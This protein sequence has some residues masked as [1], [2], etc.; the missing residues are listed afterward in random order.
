M[1]LSYVLISYD[2]RE[3]LLSTL[4]R[5]NGVTP[6]PPGDWEVIVV[7]NA[8]TD[9]SPDAVERTFPNV[10]LVRNERNIGMPARN[11]GFAM[12]RGD[13]IINLDDDSYPA[14]PAAVLRMLQYMDE[15]PACAAV[16]ARAVLPDGTAEA[17][18]LPT[19]LLGCATCLR[20]S[21]LLRVGGFCTDFL[22]QAEEYDLSFR[23]WA[24]GFTIDSFEAILFRHE[25]VDGPGR[26]LPLVCRMDLRNNLIVAGR[27]LPPNLWREY[28]RDWLLRYSAIARSLGCRQAARL[29]TIAGLW[30]SFGERLRA[31]SR[32]DAQSIELIFGLDHQKKLIAEWSASRGMKYV[33]IADFGKN[34]YATYSAC[35][36]AGLIVTAIADDNPAFDGLLYRD[37]PIRPLADV[38][39]GRLDGVVLSNIN[40]V[41]ID[42]K[43]A[44]IRRVY[45]GPA[46]RLWQP[47]YVEIPAAQRAQAA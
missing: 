36:A 4:A 46:L 2:R 1:R 18:A 42:A 38:L 13:F 25:K 30:R 26:S 43:M 24:A 23:I 27:F 40:P 47:R 19:V 34:L 37:L 20:R 17:P 28:R 9:G 16:V 22:R 11:R 12:A 41:Q 29:G 39:K 3:A 35:Q 14:E 45:A 31:S 7:D 21:A 6:L 15:H 32:L 5:L 44:A 33:A 8:S 10:R